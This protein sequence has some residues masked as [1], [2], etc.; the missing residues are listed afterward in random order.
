MAVVNSEVEADVL[1]SLYFNYGPDILERDSSAEI[2]PPEKTQTPE[3]AN[4]IVHIGFYY[5]FI[6]GKYFTVHGK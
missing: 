3:P 5:K 1:R 6:E 4:A 2:L